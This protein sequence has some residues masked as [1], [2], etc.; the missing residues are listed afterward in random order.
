MR[1]HRPL[2]QPIGSNRLGGE[3][4]LE[5]V[6]DTVRSVPTAPWLAATTAL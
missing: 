3:T 6:H 2:R 5:S 1:L 4:D